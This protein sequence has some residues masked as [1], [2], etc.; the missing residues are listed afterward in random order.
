MP[1][2]APED[3]LQEIYD[4]ELR[5][6]RTTGG[7]GGGVAAEVKVLNTVTT[8]PEKVAEFTHGWINVGEVATLIK[9]ANP[10]RKAIVLR[11]MSDSDDVR[12][13][14]EAIDFMKKIWG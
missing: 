7:G 2:K 9:G 1:V 8:R 6:I 5:A 10:D 4:H 11:N 13:G 12:I 3:I 14:Y